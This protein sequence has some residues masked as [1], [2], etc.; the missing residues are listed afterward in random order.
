[1]AGTSSFTLELYFSGIFVLYLE[2]RSVKPAWGSVLVPATPPQQA[3]HSPRIVFEEDSWIEGR[4]EVAHRTTADSVG[5]PIAEVELMGSRSLL[6]LKLHGIQEPTLTADWGGG[7]ASL[8][9]MIDANAAAAAAGV[10][11]EIPPDR[12]ILSVELPGGSLHSLYPVRVDRT[13]GTFTEFADGAFLR[14]TVVDRLEIGGAGLG[15]LLQ[16]RPGPLAGSVLRVAILNLPVASTDGEFHLHHLSY[17]L[18]DLDLSSLGL[19][20][21][22][23][24]SPSKPCPNGVASESYP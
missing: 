3:A 19:E 11:L 22:L 13:D 9:R 2:D 15:D 20:P 5:R 21:K 4:D 18:G 1:M 7:S 6:E 23:V 16:L 10:Q 12:Q 14:C 8:S 24:T 17:G